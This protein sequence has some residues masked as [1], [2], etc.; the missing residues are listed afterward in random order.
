MKNLTLLLALTLSS[1]AFCQTN[2]LEGSWSSF[3]DTSYI[4]TISINNKTGLIEK[5]Y[6]YSYYEQDDKIET[7]VSQ[8]SNTLKTKHYFD[9]YKWTVNSKFVSINDTLMKRVTTGSSNA[10][11]LYK[12]INK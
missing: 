5:V 6:S 8:D 10:T 7:I 11:L 3:D 9:K 1:I 2:K 4:T 12:K